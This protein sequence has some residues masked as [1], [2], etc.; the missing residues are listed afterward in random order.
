MDSAS[1][2]FRRS[3]SFELFLFLYLACV[4]LLQNVNI[5][6]TN[7]H[8]IDFNLVVFTVVI[9]G[10]RL[11][12][13]VLQEL[14]QLHWSSKEGGRKEKSLRRWVTAVCT[15]LVILWSVVRVIQQTSLFNLLFL[16]YPLLLYL[17]LFGFTLEPRF[18][19]S[20]YEPP[21]SFLQHR[22]Y[23]ACIQSQLLNFGSTSILSIIATT[24]TSRSPTHSPVPHHTDN[25]TTTSNSH[26]STNSSSSSS[27]ERG[28]Q[29][30][31][32]RLGSAGFAQNSTPHH[33]QRNSAASTESES[34]AQSSPPVVNVPKKYTWEYGYLLP[35]TPDE[36]R[37][38]MEIL[39]SDLIV[40]LKQLLFNSLLCAYYA[41]FI[42]MQ[43]ADSHLYYDKWWC[44][45]HAF[46]VWAN[47]FIILATHLLPPSYC[48]TLHQCTLH[49]GCWTR[50][51]H[52]DNANVWSPD[53]IWPYDSV[54]QWNGESFK[55]E[56]LQNVAVP[57]NSSQECFFLLFHSRLHVH[58][59]LLSMQCIIVAFQIV[60]L[61][62]VCFWF[63]ALSLSVFLAF[64][65]FVL[66]K[67]LYNRLACRNTPWL[68]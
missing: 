9:L 19:K 10:R 50:C 62:R 64:N 24:P 22:S 66:Y 26:S 6:K 47:S 52:N 4:L 36:V 27:S 39:M 40:R 30:F 38:E 1:H 3:L 41:G 20:R 49:L 61:L 7:I 5:Y 51:L 31:S 48:Q 15:L 2:L 45:E 32:Q 17:S 11:A 33:H 34:D 65:Y 18:Y 44:M 14:Q 13:S 59:W 28:E 21:T 42:P 8:L 25:H 46:L 54:V 43:F 35:V 23:S 56:G 37:R 29:M 68:A 60:V 53:V 58:T 55:G 57:C 12:W 16:F 63:Q 67:L